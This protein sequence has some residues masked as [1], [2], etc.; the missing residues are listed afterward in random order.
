[1]ATVTIKISDREGGGVDINLE[2]D[3]MIPL[4]EGK[5]DGDN[6]TEAM[7]AG[8]GMVMEL[9][10]QHGEGEVEVEPWDSP[11]NPHKD[12]DGNPQGGEAQ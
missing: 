4:S 3:T 11:E 12:G 10:D 6:A 1:M 8:I 5:I 2:S 7:I 9:Y